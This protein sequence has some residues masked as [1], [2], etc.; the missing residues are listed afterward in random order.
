MARVADG[1]APLFDMDTP[2]ERTAL[3]VVSDN[4]GSATSLRFWSDAV[5]TGVDVAS[6]ELFP[7]CLANAPCGA[8]S[9]HFGV[10]GPNMTLLGDGDALL[11]AWDT[12]AQDLASHRVAAA[13]VI[14]LSFGRA[15]TGGRALGLRAAAANGETQQ[16]MRAVL[17]VLQQW[18]TPAMSPQEALHF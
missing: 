15:D 13:V 12:A 16:T 9:R 18:L 7:W 8:L 4:A 5:R 11:S 6:P 1:L 2:R 14:A 17:D 3:I 10:T